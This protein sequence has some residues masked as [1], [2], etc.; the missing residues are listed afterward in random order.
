[1]PTF[2]KPINDVST[3]V[4]APGYTH[5]SGSLSV[6]TGT[7]PLFGTTFPLIVVAVR[8]E[9]ILSILEVTG[10]VGD[11]LTVL[12]AIE[13]TTD[14]DLLTG[15][16]VE[17]RP[18]ALAIVELQD[19]IISD[20]EAIAILQS[21][22]QPADDNLTDLAGLAHAKGQL[23]VDTGAAWTV[24]PPGS[25]TNVLT[26]DST[27]AAGVK[28]AAAGGGGLTVGTTAVSGGTAGRVLFEAAGPVVSDSANL[29]F[30]GATLTVPSVGSN[31][32]GVGAVVSG[33]QPLALGD[34]ANA[35]G[36]YD[37]AIGA[38][39]FTN[40]N[41]AAIA[42]G[43][44]TSVTHNNSIALGYSATSTA[45][46]QFTVGATS[47]GNT[48]DEW[49]ACSGT[50]GFRLRSRGLSSTSTERDLAI[51]DA[52]FLVPTDASYT[53]KLTLSTVGFNGPHEAMHFEDTGVIAQP[54]IPIANVRNAT[55][56]TAAAALSP[57]VPIGGLYRNGSVLMIRVS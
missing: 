30:D 18:T 28:W 52:T 43:A 23:I 53:G 5:G 4:A 34:N 22:K 56:D 25:D 14:V 1:M 31:C 7:G 54:V 8:S 10:R 46:N 49:V 57:P 45:T 55:D 16:T 36:F 27:Q 42:L 35:I 32:F 24:L 17:M 44:F 19:A 29:T 47:S 3:T 21:G 37:I 41:A 48:V 33:F 13:G 51:I 9:A 26:L 50:S 2:H 39:A 11:T 40:A 12:G 38:G 20:E 6:A 15:D